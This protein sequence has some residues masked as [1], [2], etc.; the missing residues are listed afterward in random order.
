MVWTLAFSIQHEVEKYGAYVA[1]ASFLGLALLSILYFAQAREVRRLRDW[2]GRAPERDAELEARVTSQANAAR[3][4]QPGPRPA[5]AAAAAA[6]GATAASAPTR[7][8]S[9]AAAPANGRTSAPISVPMGPRPATAAAA[10]AAATAAAAG[11]AETAKAPEAGDEAEAEAQQP[12]GAVATDEV[13][14]VAPVAPG[15]DDYDDDDD[16]DETGEEDAV[17]PAGGNGSGSPTSIPRATPRPAPRPV[18]QLRSG[19]GARSTTVPPRR[20]TGRPGGPAPVD[21]DGEGSNR[22]GIILGVLAGIVVVA[23]AAVLIVTLS[24][25]STPKKVPPNRTAPPAGT[26]TPSASANT[27]PTRADTEVVILN[28]TTTDGLA[29]KAKTTLTGAGYTADKVPTST[30]PNQATPTSTVYY[31]RGRRRQALAVGR[32]LHISRI[33]SIDPDTQTLADNSS[34]PP[35]KSDVVVVLGADQT[36]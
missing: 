15:G 12:Q 31:A 17:A 1:V 22:R 30:D 33:A 25:G 27:G 11:A 26:S 7:V 28:G 21:T 23:V 34:N 35:V 29:A 24:G 20:I 14:A 10:I 36:P 16:F 2:A 4:V 3:R 6:A 9:P 18:Q 5:P 32:A 19:A 8:T 13:P